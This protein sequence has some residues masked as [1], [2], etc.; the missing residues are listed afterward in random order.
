[1]IGEGRTRVTTRIRDLI[2]IYRDDAD[3]RYF[4]E[5]TI[6]LKRGILIINLYSISN[7]NGLLELTLTSRSKVPDEK[8]LRF[9]FTERIDDE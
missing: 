8:L 5:G 3:R 6:E 7:F 9:V 2:D 4:T 1:M